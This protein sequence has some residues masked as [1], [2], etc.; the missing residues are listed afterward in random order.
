MCYF[1]KE[2]M[3]DFL[4]FLMNFFSKKKGEMIIIIKYVDLGQIM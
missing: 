3:K 1:F 4:V 2:V